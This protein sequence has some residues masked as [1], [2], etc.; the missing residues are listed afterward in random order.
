M[1]GLCIESGSGRAVFQI[2]G[3]Q[4]VSGLY[5]DIEDYISGTGAQNR[6]FHSLLNAFWIWMRKTDSWQF[7]NGESVIDL[8]TPSMDDFRGLF[9]SRYGA[10]FSHIEY[11]TESKGMERVKTIEEVPQYALDDFNS[12]NRK[13]LKGVLKS[14][15]EYGKKERREAID[16]L[17]WIIG[18]SGC[19]DKKVQEIIQG[20]TTNEEKVREVFQ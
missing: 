3:E 19:N 6:A 14:W 4:P 11:V 12:G 8:S 18:L 20:M 9:K 5:Y 2:N 10:G 16:N 1:T 17:F 7:E 13:R 15:S